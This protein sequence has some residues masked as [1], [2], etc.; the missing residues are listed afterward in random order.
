MKRDFHDRRSWLILFNHSQRPRL[1]SGHGTVNWPSLWDHL[2]RSLSLPVG[3]VMHRSHGHWTNW[4]Q[5]LTAVGRAPV[6]SFSQERMA[7]GKGI[8]LERAG[9]ALWHQKPVRHGHWEAGK[10]DLKSSG[11]WPG[12]GTFTWSAATFKALGILGW[13]CCFAQ[14][15]W[16]GQGI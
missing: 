12:L 5:G 11:H 1:F 3:N 7:L 2:N 10:E 6:S 9:P 8:R 13:R 4:P 14:S 16:S 15:T